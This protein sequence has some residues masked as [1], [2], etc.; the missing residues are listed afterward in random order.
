MESK[1]KQ[2]LGDIRKKVLLADD[3]K[4]TDYLSYLITTAV[5]SLVDNQGDG[6]TYPRNT[7]KPI[8]KVVAEAEISNKY[9]STPDKLLKRLPTNMQGSVKASNP[10]MVKNIIPQ[11]SF[12]YLA[13]YVAS[14]LY[15]GR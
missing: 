8:S 12:V 7:N 13:A 3:G 4:N 11:P 6:P 9:S 14:S 2:I 10:Y 1:Y 5:K 15:M